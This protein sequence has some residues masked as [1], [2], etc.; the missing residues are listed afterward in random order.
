MGLAIARTFGAQGFNVA[1]LSNAPAALEPLVTELGKKGI[2]AA[3]FYADVLDRRSI[4]TG[5]DAA[6]KRF[7]QIDVLEV[8]PL[9]PAM[10]LTPVVEV[11]P[12]NVQ[13]FID[14]TVYGAIVAANYVLPDMVRRGSGTIA[15]DR[16]CWSAPLR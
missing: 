10:L 9:N 4:M 11:T 5:L 1:L 6:K 7:G 14:F 13:P 12:E 15:D 8:S 16:A 3:A 2:T